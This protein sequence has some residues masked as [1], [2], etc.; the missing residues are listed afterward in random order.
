M[1]ILSLHG[2]VADCWAETTANRNND[3]TAQHGTKT[4][5]TTE[6]HT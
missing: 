6:K 4:K 1:D 5:T 2:E 3:A